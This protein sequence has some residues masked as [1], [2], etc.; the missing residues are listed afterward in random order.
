MEDTF[1]FFQKKKR[2]VGLHFKCVPKNAVMTRVFYF[3]FRNELLQLNCMFRHSGHRY[4]DSTDRERNDFERWR[5][6]Y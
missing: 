4:S 2:V 1:F 3:E 6:V 5:L